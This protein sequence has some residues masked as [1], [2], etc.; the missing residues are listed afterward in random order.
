[1]GRAGPPG[2]EKLGLRPESGRAFKPIDRSTG[3]TGPGLKNLKAHGPAHGPSH[4]PSPRAQPMGQAHGPPL[5]P[6]LF[7]GPFPPAVVC[8]KNW[9]L[10]DKR[11]HDHVREATLVTDT[12]NLNLSKHEWIHDN[13]PSPE[14]SD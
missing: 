9:N 11:L 3:W 5:A 4:G 10:T 1:M 7:P 2:Q 12:E 8:L 6:P 14:N 13:S